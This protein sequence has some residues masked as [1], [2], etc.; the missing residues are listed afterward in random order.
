ME[1]WSRQIIERDACPVCGRMLSIR[2]RGWEPR[3][4]TRTIR[5]GCMNACPGVYET[6]KFQD[7]A[8][9]EA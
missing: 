9:K 7:P 5:I 8:F 3:T 2:G 4:R 6:V 1:E